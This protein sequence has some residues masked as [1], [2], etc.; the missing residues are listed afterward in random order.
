MLWKM[1]VINTFTLTPKV[2]SA[3]YGNHNEVFVFISQFSCVH[4][5]RLWDV[6]TQGGQSRELV[7]QTQMVTRLGYLVL[8]F[9]MEI[10]IYTHARRYISARE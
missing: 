7:S 1:Y 4:A 3:L 8:S 2:H 5:P 9:M 6:R 10:E